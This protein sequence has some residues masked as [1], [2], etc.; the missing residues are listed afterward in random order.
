MNT[1]KKYKIKRICENNTITEEDYV[2]IEYKLD[3][4]VNNKKLK[5]I[6]CTPKSIKQ[7]IVGFL[8][9][10]GIID[11]IKQ[12]NNINIDI[13]K[14]K[15]YVELERVESI[16][17]FNN[18]NNNYEK[19]DKIL[20]NKEK[21][22]ELV[23]SFMKKSSLFKKTGG[24]HS[25]ALCDF[26]K[27]IYF[28]EDIGRHNAIDK[29]IGRALIE[30]IALQDKLMLTSGRVPIEILKKVAKIKIPILISRSAPTSLAVEFANKKG[31][32][33]IGFA[34]G[35]KFNIYSNYNPL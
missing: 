19:T 17:K 5:T 26:D 34:R 13:E 9:Y 12:V 6:Y 7:L 11:S 20:Q 24:V 29:V 23:N 32:L 31:I 28:E 3:L 30:N 22:F 14:N 10:E 16:L 21:I 27:I 25:C 33:L 4:F 2:T 8:V 1:I 15:A 18:R 35:N